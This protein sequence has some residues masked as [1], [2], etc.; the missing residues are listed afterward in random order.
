MSTLAGQEVNSD[1][2]SELLS[3]YDIDVMKAVQ[4]FVLA[5][6]YPT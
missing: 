2:P 1:L 3:S 5:D 4:R 6:Y